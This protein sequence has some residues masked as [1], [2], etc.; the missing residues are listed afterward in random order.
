ML[1]Y[2]DRQVVSYTMTLAFSLTEIPSSYKCAISRDGSKLV[3]GKEGEGFHLY[4]RDTAAQIGQFR[5]PPDS[6]GGSTPVCFVHEDVFLVGGSQTGE[7]RLWDVGS[8]D[9]IQ[10]LRGDAVD[11]IVDI[12]VCLHSVTAIRNISD[13]ILQAYHRL[14]EKEDED[15][16]VIVSATHSAAYIWKARD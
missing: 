11:P 8:G 3:V 4:F 9:R 5:I 12:S 16:F 15:V 10:T 6:S 13:H 14:E 2:C 7:V 1:D